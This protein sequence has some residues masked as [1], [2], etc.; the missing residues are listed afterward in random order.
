MMPDRTPA[1]MEKKAMSTATKE[2]RSR[3]TLRPAK[4]AEDM[5]AVRHLFM[6]YGKSFDFHICFEGFE[7]ELSNLPGSY[8]PPEGRLLLAELDGKPVGVVALKA[9]PEPGVAEIKRLYVD[10]AA[11]GHGLG[12]RL[13]EAVIDAAR[14]QGY[15]KLRLETLAVMTAANTIYDDLG[16]TLAADQAGEIV[17]KE[18]RL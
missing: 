16:F 8:A 3:V 14:T 12:R 5:D 4:G 13:T 15:R 1:A 10:P 2:A 17:V 7:K 11:R 9:S 6:Q 18:L